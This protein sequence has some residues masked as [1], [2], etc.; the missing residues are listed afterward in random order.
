MSCSRWF[1]SF[2]VQHLEIYFFCFFASKIKSLSFLIYLG[3]TPNTCLRRLLFSIVDILTF[4]R[5]PGT[6]S[7]CAYYRLTSGVNFINILW[8]AFTL[9]DPESTQKLLDLTV[10][11]VLLVS[12][13]LK[14]ARRMLV[15][16]TPTYLVCLLDFRLKQICIHDI[17]CSVK[18]GQNRP[19]KVTWFKGFQS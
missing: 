14:A 12:G 8:A 13:S 11:L 5:I 6:K 7:V 2:F 1:S 9:P 18:I 19:K 4:L 15:K 17:S 3:E 10:F 16:L